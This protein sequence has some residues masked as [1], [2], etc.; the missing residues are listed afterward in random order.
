MADD[1]AYK[2]FFF[3]AQRRNFSRCMPPTLACNEKPI[4]AHSIQNARVIEL[5]QSDGHVMMPRYRI[6]DDK[7]VLELVKISRNEAS[8]FTGLCGTH[9]REIFNAIRPACQCK[10]SR[11]YACCRPSQS[12]EIIAEAPA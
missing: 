9:D 12:Y 10:C 4:R 7:P 2:R 11:R 3:D 6:K 5:I 1:A 8:T